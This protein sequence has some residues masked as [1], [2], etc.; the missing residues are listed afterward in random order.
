MKVS[1]IIAAKDAGAFIHVALASVLAQTLSDFEVIV[2]ND[3]SRDT[4]G[5]VVRQF[6]QDD[7]R[8]ML[9]EN[10]ISTGVSGARNRGLAAASGEWIALLD[11]DDEFA[12]D[13]L[14]VL[15]REAEQRQLDLLADNMILR[16]LGTRSPE[17][18]AFPG[19]WMSDA[20][21]L[22]LPQLLTRDWPDS[23]FL[24]F[25]YVKPIIRRRFLLDTGLQYQGD[26]W[27]A[28]DFLFYAEA[29]L[30]GAAFGVSSSAQY[31]RYWRD[32]SL[33][34]D[35]P[36]MHRELGRVNQ[37]VM[38]AACRN[39]PAALPIL[40]RRQGELDYVAASRAAKAGQL[41]AAVRLGRRVPLRL[42]AGKVAAAISRRLR[43]ALFQLSDLNRH[44]AN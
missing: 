7:P 41:A 42:M 37:L 12:P 11:A 30:R 19:Y 16:Q 34:A 44:A 15:V 8:V 5:D 25:G 33:S 13:R 14:A 38:E 35:T 1:I 40:R 28:E 24:P 26:V 4:T 17:Q 39:A 22:T 43:P 9:L 3:G 2:I 23:P 32:G 10:K 21:P 31:I 27:C 18:I 6:Q 20:A 36:A 29:I